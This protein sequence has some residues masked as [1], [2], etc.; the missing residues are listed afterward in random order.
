MGN[1]LAIIQSVRSSETDGDKAASPLRQ[2]V[3]DHDHY[4]VT[5]YESAKLEVSQLVSLVMDNESLL[6]KVNR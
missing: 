3:G 1:E 4:L 6:R 5:F 2:P